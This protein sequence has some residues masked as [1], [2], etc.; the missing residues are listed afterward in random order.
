MPRNESTAFSTLT[1]SFLVYI[2]EAFVFCCCNLSSPKDLKVSPHGINNT[3]TATCLW[4]WSC[5]FFS[6]WGH[7]AVRCWSCYRKYQQ[8]C[9]AAQSD[10]VSSGIS[11]CYDSTSHR[12][13]IWGVY[14]PVVWSVG[15]CVCLSHTLW[16]LFLSCSPASLVSSLLLS[17]VLSLPCCLSGLS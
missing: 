15:L 13:S 3:T 12:Q 5:C 10:D 16:P 8:S 11:R 1:F 4:L 9:S 6:F 7:G 14:L 17:S 2:T